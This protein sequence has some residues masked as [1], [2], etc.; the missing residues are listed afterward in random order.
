MFKRKLFGKRGA[1]AQSQ[2]IVFTAPSSVPSLQDVEPDIWK[3]NGTAT[4]ILD[5]NG[6]IVRCNQTALNLLGNTHAELLGAQLQ[7]IIPDFPLSVST[8][9]YNLAYAVFHSR[10]SPFLQQQVNLK[11]GAKI[12]VNVAISKTTQNRRSLIFLSML[13]TQ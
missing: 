8:P 5:I 3:D 7:K 4:V 10:N 13:P 12:S 2:N 1:F 9:Y 11:D 6:R